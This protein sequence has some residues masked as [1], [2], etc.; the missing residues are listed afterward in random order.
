MKFLTLI[1]LLAAP[2]ADIN[3]IA[4]VNSLKKQ[5][6]QA[7]EVEDFDLAISTLKTLTDSMNVVE[8]EIFLNLGNSYF[9]KNDTTNAF[10]FYTKVLGSQEGNL[11]S[12]AYQQ[13][14]VI[15]QQQNK[16]EE[17]LG[18]FKNSLISDPTNADARYNY[19]L[20]KRLLDQQQQQQKNDDNIEPSEYAKRLKEQADKLAQNNQFEQALQIMQ[21]GL[22]E[23]KTVSAYNQFITKLGEVVESKQ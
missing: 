22:K 19:E 6:Q 4:K 16:L 13:M 10:N 15:N 5:A 7:I 21:M 2:M 20:L 18:N 11:R 3:K 12:R 14:G 8:D 17:A 23:D 9:H 1:I